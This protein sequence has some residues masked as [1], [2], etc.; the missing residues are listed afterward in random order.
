MNGILF[1]L[2][3]VR[4]GPSTETNPPSSV[5]PTNFNFVSASPQSGRFYTKP[6][7][8]VPNTNNANASSSTNNSPRYESKHLHDSGKYTSTTTSNEA[9]FIRSNDSGSDDVYNS[10]IYSPPSRP[11]PTSPLRASTNSNKYSPS[12]PPPATSS[13]PSSLLSSYSSSQYEVSK[14]NNNTPTYTTKPRSMTY[15]GPPYSPPGR[16][17]PPPP[18]SFSPTHLK[19]TPAP[20]NYL[21]YTGLQGRSNEGTVIRKKYD[22]L[23]L[24]YSEVYKYSL[25][26]RE[27]LRR[28]TR[29][30]DDRSDNCMHQIQRDSR[31]NLVAAFSGS[32]QSDSELSPYPLNRKMQKIIARLSTDTLPPYSSSPTSSPHSPHSPHNPPFS[33]FANTFVCSICEQERDVIN[34]FT[35]SVCSHRFCT[36]VRYIQQD[37]FRYLPYLRSVWKYGFHIQLTKCNPQILPAPSNH[38]V[39]LYNL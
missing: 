35:L 1:Y 27:R 23:I 29:I 37:L 33:P 38:V 9:A 14:M 3:S 8:P 16:A 28:G 2:I 18:V 15:N 6:R 26:E 4:S 7:S 19:Q 21:S 32:E 30:E 24:R 36:Q 12:L 13:H 31:S 10:M 5:S 39:K 22:V 34:A 25:K 20:L 17:A 11:A